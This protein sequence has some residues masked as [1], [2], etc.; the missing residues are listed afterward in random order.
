VWVAVT[1][2]GWSGSGRDRVGFGDDVAVAG[3]LVAADPRDGE[4][5]FLAD[6]VADPLTGV[7][8]ALVAEEALARGGSWFVDAPLARAAAFAA[9]LGP[10]APS[11]EPARRP[12]AR[13]PD[14]A[15]RPLGAD[16]TAVWAELEP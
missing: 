1:A 2:H 15:I 5:R 4:P 9:G 7:L 8:A 12:R 11:P 14:G 16:T 13:R 6:A 3:G 10:V